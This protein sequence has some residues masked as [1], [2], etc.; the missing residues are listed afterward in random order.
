[1]DRATGFPPS[2]LSFNND[3][4]MAEDRE[5]GLRF[6]LFK[7]LSRITEM[8]ALALPDLDQ[9][10]ARKTRFNQSIVVDS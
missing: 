4:E 8:Q 1:M 5:R 7:W 9:N 10:F 2:S 6:P 3:Q